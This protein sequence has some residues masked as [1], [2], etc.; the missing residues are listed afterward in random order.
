MPG[1]TD[2]LRAAKDPEDALWRRVVE[3]KAKGRLTNLTR[4]GDFSKA[5]ADKTLLA[6]WE[7]WQDD[8]STGTFSRN[9]TVRGG[10]AKATRVKNGGIMQWHTVKTGYKYTLQALCKVEGAAR[11]NVSVRWK[12]DKGD[13]VRW[14]EDVA[15]TAEQGV[16]WTRYTGVV[17]VP[18][19]AQRMAILLA[20]SEQTGEKDV[21]W[22]D[23]VEL[24]A[25]PPVSFPDEMVRR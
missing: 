2:V 6:D 20:V 4:N 8:G 13:W 10:V 21:C 12:T 14:D 25:V 23:D 15:L 3:R 19:N 11:A 18:K 16:D 5:D 7:S 17:T 22:F 9:S 1:L 24:D